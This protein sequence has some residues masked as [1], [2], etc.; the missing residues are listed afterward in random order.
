M[1]QPSMLP[2]P[3]VH[4]KAKSHDQATSSTS[5]PQSGNAPDGGNSRRG[6]N[7][8]QR[9]SAVPALSTGWARR[10]PQSTLTGLDRERSN[11][12][13]SVSH[14]HIDAQQSTSTPTD[15]ADSP[16]STP[17]PPFTRSELLP[18]PDY[19]AK[20]RQSTDKGRKRGWSFSDER[21]RDQRVDTATPSSSS[22]ALYSASTTPTA[23]QV[24]LS[25]PPRI[26]A[27]GT[28]GKA[29]AVAAAAK[30][31]K[32]L[33][34]SKAS[35]TTTNSE[36][37]KARASSS[38]SYGLDL[39]PLD[40]TMMPPSI[41]NSSNL[42]PAN[43]HLWC[44]APLTTSSSI[45]GPETRKPCDDKT[46]A[47]Y[48]REKSQQERARDSGSGSGSGSGSSSVTTADE[49]PIAASPPAI[50]RQQGLGECP[51]SSRLHIEVS[52]SFSF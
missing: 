47:D 10:A 1:Q 11:L 29:K 30:I 43:H 22:T 4:D 9:A 17:V 39:V 41:L 31:R 14:L 8:D 34:Q 33:T 49:Q 12:L 45:F 3:S 37:Q 25:V 27:Q 42:V 35:T 26:A 18:P 20:N 38:S 2:P 50:E 32:Q 40:S 21:H 23:S 48:A 36:E 44:T 19:Q 52:L 7:S 13:R 46:R 5:S 28:A 16:T 24:N 15:D 51:R 6:S